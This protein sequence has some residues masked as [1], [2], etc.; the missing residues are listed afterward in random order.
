MKKLIVL[1]LLLSGCSTFTLD[2]LHTEGAKASALCIKGGYAMAGGEVTGAKVN[3]DF[4]GIVAIAPDCSIMI[5]RYPQ[6]MQ[7]QPGL[8]F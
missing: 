1:S 6:P 2:K 3:D 8:V 5:Q 7:P 4:I